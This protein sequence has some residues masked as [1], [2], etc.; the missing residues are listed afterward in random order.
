M[1]LRRLRDA[2][3]ILT[4]TFL[5]AEVA[6]RALPLVVG[7]PLRSVIREAERIPYSSA[8]TYGGTRVLL[9]PPAAADIVVVGD[10]F[11]FGTYV[12]AA[13]AFPSLLAEQL[14]TTVINLAVGSQAPA[15]YQ[16]MVEL[17]ARY[18]PRLVLYCIFANDFIDEHAPPQ[19]LDEAPFGSRPGDAALYVPAIGWRDR[20]EAMA[21]RASNLSLLNLLRKIYA[22]PAAANQSVP[23]RRAGLSYLFAPATYWDPQIDWNVAAVQRAT[24]TNAEFVRMADA[25]GRQKGFRL[26]VVLV[27]SKELVHGPMVGDAIYRDSHY[28]TYQ[29][30]SSLVA[31]LQIPVVDLT[32]ELRARAAQGVQLYHTIDGHWNEAGHRAA[33]EVLSG[34]V[35]DRR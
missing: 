7:D 1:K 16:R 20:A 27:P 13:D 8:R 4:T 5:F 28:R 35:N 24:A 18:T 21:R 33:A 29:E 3:I 23:W 14:H 10:S 12:R 30:L 6:L 2:L 9:P 26:V 19:P 11:P 34:V 15:Q 22:Q 17:S 25:F 31:A 32:P